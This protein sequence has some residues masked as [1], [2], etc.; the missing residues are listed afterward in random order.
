MRRWFPKKC[1]FQRTPFPCSTDSLPRQELCL[2]GCDNITDVGLL[3]AAR[4]CQGLRAIGLGGC[5]GVSAQG[6]AMLILGAPNL[7][8]IFINR[9]RGV[10]D[11]LLARVATHCPQLCQ[12][13][14]GRCREVTDAGLSRLLTGCRGLQHLTLDGC[15]GL[16]DRSC[17]HLA[18][19]HQ[20]LSLQLSGCLGLTGAGVQRLLQKCTKLQDLRIDLVPVLDRHLVKYVCFGSCTLWASKSSVSG[21]RS[22]YTDDGTAL[23]EKGRVQRC[24]SDSI[25]AP[26]AR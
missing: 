23:Q 22:G 14:I 9:V 12:I 16:T 3:A 5:N 21:R 6:V 7:Q 10:D 25:P 11:E 8:R 18:G 20:L 24:I 15:T 17:D 19:S 4:H 2:D 13:D 1:W 26:G